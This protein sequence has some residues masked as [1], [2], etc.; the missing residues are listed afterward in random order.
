MAECAYFLKAEFQTE[1][2]A[3]A[4]A[5]KMDEF[6]LE[7]MKAYSFYQKE[8]EGDRDA[9]RKG[10]EQKFPLVTEY[11][12]KS[13]LWLKLNLSCELDF[14]Q[15]ENNETIVQGTTVS[16]CDGEIWHM[17]DW[18]NV[19]VFIKKKFGAIKVVWGNEENGCGSLDSLNLYDWEQIVRDILK[20]KELHPLLI[21]TNSELDE[22]LDRT[23]KQDKPKKEP[24]KI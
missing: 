7:S 4:M 10:L 9:F 19:C 14:G 8:R 1:A 23:L 5:K 3:H 22:L 15:D 17:A 13:G 21:H 6:F 11:I 18:T 2:I 16:W 12:K 20:N 24:R